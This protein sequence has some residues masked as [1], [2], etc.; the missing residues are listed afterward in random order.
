MR[1][2]L[3]SSR[4]LKEI[5]RDPLSYVFC[6]GFP[7]IMLI[8]FQVLNQY[9]GGN[10]PSFELPVLTPGI[11]VFS[12]SFV[13][14]YL[15]LSVS[16]DRATSF[17]LRIYAS[18]MTKTDFV[19][20]YTMPGLLIAAAQTVICYALSA[21]IGLLTGASFM[22]LPQSLASGLSVLPVSLF[23]IGGGILFGSLFS[24]KSA[25]GLCSIIISL[26]GILGGAWMPL[27]AMG[28]FETFCRFLPFYPAVS[29]GRYFGGVS[30]S[31]DIPLQYLVIALYSAV[32]FLLAIAGFGHAIH[33][34]AN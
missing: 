6:L 25:P 18:P 33:K 32:I 3:F 34:D 13:M 30:V 19:L 4:N 26:S 22:N 23:F 14:L 12:Y 28:D 15:A 10:T 21:V 7:M 5:A 31:A 8:L 11:T 29:I 2:V 17:L 16:K 20:S 1:A 24:E 27:E 9:T